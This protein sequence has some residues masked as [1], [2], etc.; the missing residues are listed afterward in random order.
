MGSREPEKRGLRIGDP[1]RGW[2]AGARPTRG[3]QFQG[4]T[5]VSCRGD[6]VNAAFGKAKRQHIFPREAQLFPDRPN[7][8]PPADCEFVGT[9]AAYVG[10]LLPI[11]YPVGTPK[12]G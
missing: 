8:A 4:F 11:Q 10:T 2:G 1:V 9:I 6:E 3:R 5:I 7:M 12:N